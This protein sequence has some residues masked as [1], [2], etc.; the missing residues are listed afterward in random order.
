[1]T[2]KAEENRF[3]FKSEK[4]KEPMVGVVIASHGNLANEL[5]KTLES[6]TGKT[7]QIIP[8]SMAESYDIELL[9]S[10]LEQAIS[11]VN[12][13]KGVL[14]LTDMFGGTPSNICLSFLQKGKIDVLTGVNLPMLVKLISNREGKTV[15]EL[16]DLCMKRGKEEI[17]VASEILSS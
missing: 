10:S 17:I 16:A 8:L 5:V 7:T 2:A 6:I 3:M 11:E 9:R 4:K 15:S 14:L 13:G 12:K 1:M